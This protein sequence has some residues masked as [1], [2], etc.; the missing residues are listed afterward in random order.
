MKNTI[1][2]D[3]FVL[4]NSE[5]VVLGVYGAA[6]HQMATESGK[7]IREQHPHCGVALHYI[8]GGKPAVGGFISMRGNLTWL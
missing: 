1:K 3:W 2:G 4:S 8:T 6:L 7:K 5:G